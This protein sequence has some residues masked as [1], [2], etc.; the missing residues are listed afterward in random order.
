MKPDLE[1]PNWSEP[2]EFERRLLTAARGERP[3]AELSA[4]MAAGLGLP[5]SGAGAANG[6]L[7]PVKVGSVV[8]SVVGVGMVGVALFG[9]VWLAQRD[10]DPPDASK[11]SQPKVVQPAAP[12]TLP[13]EPGTVDAPTPSRAVTSDSAPEPT[14]SSAP[15]IPKASS[16][17]ALERG[18][19]REEIRLIDA[20]RGAVAARAYE[21]ALSLLRRYSTTYPSGMFGQEASVLRFEALDRSGQHA[22]AKALA[23]EFLG[24]HPNSPLAERAERVAGH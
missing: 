23:R 24:R 6:S 3:S 11:L 9:G 22:H 17:G 15:S 18:D 19:L 10:G 14:A 1:L 16:A 12:Q 8:R 21:Q 2:T 4:R 13:S 20:A 5:V 7:P